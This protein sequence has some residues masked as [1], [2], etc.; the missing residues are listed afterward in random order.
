MKIIQTTVL[1]LLIGATAAA[2]RHSNSEMTIESDVLAS[3]GA[4][5]TATGAVLQGTLSQ[6]GP[7]FTSAA[8]GLTLEHGFWHP[9][10]QLEPAVADA[11]PDT[12]GYESRGF[13]KYV[14]PL[15]GTGSVTSTRA[16]GRRSA[17]SR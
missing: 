15:D 16:S 12:Y 4:R 6:P 2:G 10:V 5:A 8:P 17:A 13:F 3:A 7:V 1:V 14:C 9:D 11:G